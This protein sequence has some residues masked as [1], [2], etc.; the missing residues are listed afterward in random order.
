MAFVLRNASDI[1]RADGDIQVCTARPL[2]E[3]SCQAPQ[4]APRSAET[5][6]SST[7]PAPVAL[8]ASALLGALINGVAVG[9]THTVG[10]TAE[11]HKATH[12]SRS[13]S[14]EAIERTGWALH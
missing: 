8:A 11:A 2:F 3:S 6:A 9:C 14:I 10:H 13:R 7:A 12:H 1:N 5:R 4:Q